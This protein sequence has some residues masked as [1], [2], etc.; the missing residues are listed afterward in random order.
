MSASSLP[1]AV[2][3]ECHV[4]SN[5]K[6]VFTQREIVRVI[7]GGRE[8]GNLQ[9]YLS[10]NP[11]IPENFLAGLNMD[12]TIPGVST[13]AKGYEATALIEICDKYLEAKAQN[14]LRKSQYGLAKCAGGSIPLRSI[15]LLRCFNSV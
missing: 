1:A 7:S 13:P 14:K 9:R 12:F 2:G 11:L 15:R 5:Y 3:A 10:R 6:R 4:L 8:S